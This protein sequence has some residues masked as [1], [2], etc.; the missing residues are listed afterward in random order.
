MKELITS[1]FDNDSLFGKIMTR[2]G[3]LIGANLMFVI[4]S[5]PVITIAASITG[6]YHVM[7]KTLR[8]NGVLNP[9]KM[10]WQGFKNNFKQATIV[11]M[12]ALLLTFIFYLEFRITGIAGGNLA[13]VRYALIIIATVL[14]ILL[15]YIFPVMTAFADT[16]P[17]LLKNSFYFAVKKPLKLVIIMFFTIFPLYLTYTDAQMMPLYAFIWVTIGYSLIAM[18]GATL[19]LPEFKPFLPEVDEEGNFINEDNN[20]NKI[21]DEKNE[22]EILEDMIK[23]GM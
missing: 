10:F 5:L 23:L 19:L 18:L 2:F 4:F 7:F 6:L 8:G 1:L 9:F 14:L 3:I 21:K 12:L 13:I 11:W 15:I 17:N 20:D 16:I 22:K